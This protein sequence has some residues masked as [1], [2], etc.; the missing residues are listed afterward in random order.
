MYKYTFDKS[1]KKF[2]CP[3]CGK[4]R[5]VKYI[6]VETKTYLEDGYGRCD[7]IIECGHFKK[8]GNS[9]NTVINKHVFNKRENNF[10]SIDKET[11]TRT[12]KNYQQNNLV[13]FLLNNFTKNDVE[14]V[15]QSYKIGTSK[16]WNGSPIFWLIDETN[17]I[18]SG[19]IMG[20][21][22]LT[23]KRTKAPFNHLTWAH[24]ELKI[25][26]FNIK[27]TLFGIHLTL[28][29]LKEIA[30]VE[31]EKTALIMSL[32]KPQYTWLA[33]GGIHNLKSESLSPIKQKHITCFPDNNGYKTWSKIC[34]K[35]N[36]QGYNIYCSSILEG[37]KINSGDDIADLCLDAINSNKDNITNNSRSYYE[38]EI[39]RL[40]VINPAIKLIINQFDLIDENGDEIKF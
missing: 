24:K 5:F 6:E 37:S 27:P 32:L 4:K 19:K 28:N 1:S 13:K 40:S 17:I 14:K 21:S 39:E 3:A 18:R 20:Y 8:P 2:N 29:S 35:L 34:N 26:D 16:K 12:L 15:I 33:T 10:G 9:I 30:I 36:D 31:S 22:H 23:G 25:E 7:R 38:T 11:F